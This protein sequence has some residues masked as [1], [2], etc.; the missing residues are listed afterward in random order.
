M[1]MEIA[2]RICA[3]L[4]SRRTSANKK[5]EIRLLATDAVAV[6]IFMQES[7][8]KR[9]LCRIENIQL[10]KPLKSQSVLLLF[11]FVMLS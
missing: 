10:E 11:L 8:A 5:G 2:R 6:G 7:K 4:R 3:V 1:S 9:E